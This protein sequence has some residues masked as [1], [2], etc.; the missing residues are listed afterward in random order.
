MQEQWE[1]QEAVRIGDEIKD[2][3]EEPGICFGRVGLI[4]QFVKLWLY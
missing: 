2:I 1:L 3:L 4:L